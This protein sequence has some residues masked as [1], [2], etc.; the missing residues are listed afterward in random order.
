VKEFGMDNLNMLCDKAMGV[1]S[2]LLL[3]TFY[4]Q[5]HHPK[6]YKAHLI[7]FNCEGIWAVLQAE[8]AV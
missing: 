6:L 2:G 7:Q 8:C 4:K 3:C 1:E 5:K